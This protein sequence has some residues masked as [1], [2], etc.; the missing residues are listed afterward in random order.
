MNGFF[1]IGFIGI[2][3]IIVIFVKSNSTMRELKRGARRRERENRRDMIRGWRETR[4][5]KYGD[6]TVEDDFGKP[7]WK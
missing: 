4:K 1:D 2:I 3:I 7:H 6:I 5:K